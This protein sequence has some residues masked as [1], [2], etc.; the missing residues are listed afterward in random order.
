MSSSPGMAVAVHHT[1]ALP[2]PKTTV[3]AAPN[4]KRVE[5]RSVQFLSNPTTQRVWANKE[6]HLYPH[7]IHNSRVTTQGLSHIWLPSQIQLCD[8]PRPRQPR[9]QC[10]N[11]FRT[12]L[13]S[14]NVSSS[15]NRLRLGTAHLSDPFRG[16]M[17]RDQ[18][19]DSKSQQWRRSNNGVSNSNS[20]SNRRGYLRTTQ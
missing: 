11:S 14:A 7:Q 17:R 10:H 20:N 2:L 9:D 15:Y 8:Q 4:C 16:W 19:A 18:G 6:W 1:R 3:W 5:G 12:N 13:R